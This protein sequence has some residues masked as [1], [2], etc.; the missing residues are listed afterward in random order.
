M[1]SKVYVFL[2]FVCAVQSSQSSD[3]IRK[4]D[5]NVSVREMLIAYVFV[6]CFDILLL[7]VR[8][9]PSS[10][11]Q[12]P[13]NLLSAQ[14]DVPVWLNIF[15]FPLSKVFMEISTSSCG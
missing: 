4:Q 7:T 13:H 8:Y 15:M 3:T 1:D 9:C 5:S 11:L 6:V 14:E 10:T 12:T 2:I